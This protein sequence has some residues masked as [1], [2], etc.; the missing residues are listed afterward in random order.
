M[1]ILLIVSPFIELIEAENSLDDTEHVSALNSGKQINII[2]ESTG[3]QRNVTDWRIMFE[4]AQL[5]SALLPNPL[6][7][8]STKMLSLSTWI[9][10]TNIT[11]A[12]IYERLC[13]LDVT[14]MHEDEKSS[15]CQDANPY[16]GTYNIPPQQTIDS[17]V[18]EMYR[19]DG[20]PDSLLDV[21]AIDTDSDNFL[22]SLRIIIVTQK[23][24]E[25][26]ERFIN[27][28]RNNS[29][30]KKPCEYDSRGYAVDASDLCDWNDF[31]LNMV[32]ADKS[33]LDEKFGFNEQGLIV[34]NENIFCLPN[35]CLNGNQFQRDSPPR[36]NLRDSSII[37]YTT[38][39]KM[40]PAE[41]IT[42][43]SSH[44]ENNE[45]KSIAEATLGCSESG[46][47]YELLECT[48]LYGSTDYRQSII[49]DAFATRQNGPFALLV[50]ESQD[51]NMI[52]IHFHSDEM[53]DE[54][55]EYLESYGYRTIQYGDDGL[56]DSNIDYIL[57]STIAFLSSLAIIVTIYKVR[58]V[59]NTSGSHLSVHEPEGTKIESEPE[60][61]FNPPENTSQLSPVGPIN[62]DLN[63]YEWSTDQFERPIYRTAGSYDHWS[64]WEP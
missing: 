53:T 4:I 48:E 47:G 45:V 16:T 23:P 28:I 38:M 35:E 14:L 11:N 46:Y 42:N 18:G 60:K 54:K 63:G 33:E 22:D 27:Y 37:D 41:A 29:L 5:E 25:I 64:L 3:L 15:I 43:I 40:S 32:I 61:P 10:S 19:D 62:V 58:K 9:Q 21:L 52:W 36:F 8:K 12:L 56:G 44:F 30:E 1:L 6:S 49:I 34:M 13:E 39:M 20:S 51:F 17:I 24:S 26:K 2:V 7:D 31:G 50:N 55:I 57:I 59:K